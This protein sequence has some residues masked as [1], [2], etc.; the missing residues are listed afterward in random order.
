M[1]HT[2]PTWTSLN[3][4]PEIAQPH[5][6]HPL[7]KLGTTIVVPRYAHSPPHVIPKAVHPGGVK[8]VSNHIAPYLIRTLPDCFTSR[9]RLGGN[10][11]KIG[12]SDDLTHPTVSPDTAVLYDTRR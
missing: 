12:I 3:L 4:R 5:L 6:P 7:A 9:H 8:S 11:G 10:Q 2:E 1:A